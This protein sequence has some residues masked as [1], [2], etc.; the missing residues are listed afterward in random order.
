MKI[1][2]PNEVGPSDES[3]IGPN[4]KPKKRFTVK[5]EM[6]AGEVPGPFFQKNVYI[7]GELFDWEI[8]E[9]AYKW[10]QSKGPMILAV[11]QQDICKHFLDCLS[12]VVGRKIT[13]QDLQEA[14][15]TGWI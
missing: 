15:K 13:I 9:E 5:T 3:P 7:D 8:D 12:E 6:T 11:V 1:I 14:T 10:A 4:G 2:T